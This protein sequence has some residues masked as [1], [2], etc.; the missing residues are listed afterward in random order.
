[1]ENRGMD[2]GVVI[3]YFKD[4]ATFSIF[5]SACKDTSL[6]MV[7]SFKQ[8]FM[9]RSV[10]QYRLATKSDIP[11]LAVIRSKGWETP[12]Y[13]TLR[14]EGYMKAELH[15]QKAPA[16]RVVYLATENERVAG[17][18]AGHLTQR[19]NCD[20]ELEWIDVIEEY[21]RKGIASELLHMLAA[22]FIDHKAF[23]ICVN[24]GADNKVA[25]QFYKSNGAK[26]L[27]EH[28]LVWE[29]INVLL[30]K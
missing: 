19:F 3:L 4:K 11:A 30:K 24:S 13:W 22:W 21:R 12:D 14:I 26:D 2:K 15:P 9:D 25:H 6:K 10:V 29:N 20:G 5:G 8:N 28:W 16:P 18:I 1:M 27:Q 17:F 7:V 23:T